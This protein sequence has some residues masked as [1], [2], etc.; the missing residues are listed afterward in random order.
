MNS[1][2][3]Y[4]H[5]GENVPSSVEAIDLGLSVKWANMNVGA[6]KV[7]DFGLF[8]AWGETVPQ[9]DKQYG[10]DSYKWCEGSASSITKYMTKSSKYQVDNKTE[11]ER[12]DDAAHVNWGGQWRMPTRAE[13]C[14][15]LDKCYWVWTSSYN[16]SGISGYIVYKAKNE[17]DRGVKVF[18]GGIP[19]N[20]YNLLDIHIFLPA[21][22]SVF[23]S[24]HYDIGHTC[25]YGTSSLGT[26]S[27]NCD[28]AFVLNMKPRLSPGNV[29]WNFNPR[30]EGRSIRAVCK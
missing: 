5:T 28:K 18:Q 3:P 14:E 6:T 13:L 12:E 17:T 23:G 19:S 27:S 24:S 8:F 21:A 16:N 30:N 15:L 7:S 9:L 4:I 20:N 11:L 29:G 26:W 10:W 22:G 2:D 25:Y 1:V